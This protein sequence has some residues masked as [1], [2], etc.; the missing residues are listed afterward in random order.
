VRVFTSRFLVALVALAI[1]STLTITASATADSA[2]SDPAAL[3]LL[4]Q[5]EAMAKPSATAPAARRIAPTAGAT[6]ST[7]A[8]KPHD[9]TSV[10][11]ALR[12][13]LPKLNAADRAQASSILDFT[14]R[15][16]S[17]A[18]AASAPTGVSTPVSGEI[19]D[20]DSGNQYFAD[21]S[22][23][24]HFV[25]YYTLTGANAI[26]T[27]YLGN[28]E[29]VLGNVWNHEITGM[30]FAPP[31]V[32]NGGTLTPIRLCSI[33]ASLYG[34]CAPVTQSATDAYA[35][36]AACTLRNNYDPQTSGGY[37]YTYY[38]PK[39][40][41]SDTLAPLEVTA[42]HEFFHAVQ[43]RQAYD[44][45]LWLMEG[46]AVWMENEVYPAIHDYLQYLP[47]TGIKEPLV[48]FN[49]AVTNPGTFNQYPNAI[50]PFTVYGDFAF[51]KAFVGYL[52][53]GDVVR[54]VWN[55]LG[56]HPTA[57]ALNAVS[58]IAGTYHLSL[59]SVMLSYAQWNTLGPKS[60]PDANLYRP[61]VWWLHPRLDRSNRVLSGH[62]L[63]IR[64]LANTALA[65]TR[66]SHVLSTT[67]LQIGVSGPNGSSGGWF[68]VRRQLTNG[69][70]LVSQ[71]RIGTRGSVVTIP[72]NTSVSYVVIT[73]NN[74]ATSGSAKYFGVRAKVL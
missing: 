67:K 1:G 25:I 20:G 52:N 18:I 39:Y 3:A 58:Y 35:A 31:L 24:G 8:T 60:Y 27:D 72:F 62:R 29:T 28:V 2:P 49:V 12:Q 4:H 70:A 21:A 5:A 40:D 51:F 26:T 55:Y 43:F 56:R 32:P 74:V 16:P 13:A 33:D 37:T 48:P 19:C 30:G 64:P 57:T 11:V 22:P 6:I 14:S 68:T 50:W 53:N 65:I 23:D 42:A 61:P 71:Y 9:G 17:P 34:Y 46:T 7:L 15:V 73:L 66:G 59:T 45:P 63:T 47:A 54:L 38:D 10:M 41:G 44:E 36:S 69:K